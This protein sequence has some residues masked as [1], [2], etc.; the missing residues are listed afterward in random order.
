MEQ[1]IGAEMGC[2]TSWKLALISLMVSILTGCGEE[3][4]Y[5]LY[6]QEKPT[7]QIRSFRVHGND[8]PVNGQEQVVAG[9]N[10]GFRISLNLDPMYSDDTRILVSDRE[11][12]AS[13][14]LEQEIAHIKCGYYPF[15]NFDILLDCTFSLSN[16][17]SCQVG[18]GTEVNPVPQTYIT[19][20][21]TN[22]SPL[23]IGNQADLYVV[24]VGNANGILSGQRNILV[25]FRLN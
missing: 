21:Q 1:R 13:T 12:L 4:A 8:T 3:E 15:C 9:I 7:V 16:Q 22:I 14:N 25:T 17:I 24:L 10:N 11:D 20:P 6:S 5:S 19:L 23:L 2:R 18:A